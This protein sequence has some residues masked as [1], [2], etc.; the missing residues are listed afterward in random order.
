MLLDDYEEFD[1]YISFVE[2]RKCHMAKFFWTCY[3][4]YLNK[5]F[6][7]LKE[8][9]ESENIEINK[10]SIFYNED[11]LMKGVIAY[12]IKDYVNAKRIFKENQIKFVSNSARLIFDE[13]MKDIDFNTQ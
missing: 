5:D 2:N 4:Y 13:I 7:T 12:S 8:V 3:R 11:I 6:K 1:K 10:T 9:Y